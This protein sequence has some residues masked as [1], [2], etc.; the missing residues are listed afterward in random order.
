MEIINYTIEFVNYWQF[1]Y[2]PIY[3]LRLVELEILKIYIKNSLA[4]SFIIIRKSE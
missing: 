4:N 3:S 2:N 1:L